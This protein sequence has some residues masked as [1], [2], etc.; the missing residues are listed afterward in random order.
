MAFGFRH[1]FNF[2]V[3]L[4]GFVTLALPIAGAELSPS[5]EEA[6][7][8]KAQS[9]TDSLVSVVLFAESFSVTRSVQEMAISPHSNFKARHASVIKKLK[10]GNADILTPIKKSVHEIYPGAEIREFWIAPALAVSV[11]L[12]AIDKLA[13]LP[14]V[15]SIIQDARLEYIEPVETRPVAAASEV[16]SSH[17]EALNIPA[18]WSR[19][20][21]GTGRL[22]CNFDTGVESSHPALQSKWRGN[23][24]TTMATWFAPHSTSLTPTD[25]S[26]HG[27]HT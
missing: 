13:E 4:A 23:H 26:G 19:G 9:G 24:A 14:G 16:I 10:L 7:I 18:V 22:V 2:V 6:L 27:T 5:L 17:L 8:R 1:I 12:S 11:P 20:L 21:K 15:A 25:I 3:L